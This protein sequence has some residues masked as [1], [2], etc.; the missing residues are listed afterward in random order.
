MIDVINV[1]FYRKFI[2][3]AILRYIAAHAFAFEQNHAVVVVMRRAAAI[4]HEL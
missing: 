2:I 1:N 3:L 4:G